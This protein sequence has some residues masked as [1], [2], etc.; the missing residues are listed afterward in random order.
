MYSPDICT[1]AEIM[2]LIYDL[3]MIINISYRLQWNSKTAN[4]PVVYYGQQSGY[5]DHV[6]IVRQYHCII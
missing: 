1:G 6:R 2:E 5:Y 4:M 3:Q